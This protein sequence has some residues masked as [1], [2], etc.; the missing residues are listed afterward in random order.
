M[1]EKQ[2]EQLMQEQA[3]L[4]QE[5]NRLLSEVKQREQMCERSQNKCHNQRRVEKEPIDQL[6]AP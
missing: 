1:Y 2:R 5:V 4:R 3:H 6:G